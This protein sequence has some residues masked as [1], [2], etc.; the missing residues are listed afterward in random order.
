VAGATLELREIRSGRRRTVVTFT[1]GSFYMLGVRPGEYELVVGPRTLE[2]L[3]QTADP[4]QF[5]VA[6]GGES[7][8]N[9]DLRLVPATAR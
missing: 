5:T 3:R 8:G 9:L 1:D 2:L 7:P 4:I 6:P